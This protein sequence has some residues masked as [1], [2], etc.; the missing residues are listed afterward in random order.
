MRPP[1]HIPK[2]PTATD[3]RP[4][5]KLCSRFWNLLLP[6]LPSGSRRKALN[7]QRARAQLGQ[8]GGGCSGGWE[9]SKHTLYFGCC[10]PIFQFKGKAKSLLLGEAFLPGCGPHTQVVPS[11]W[12]PGLA[13]RSRTRIWGS[14]TSQ[15]QRQAPGNLPGVGSAKPLHWSARSFPQGDRAQA[16]PRSHP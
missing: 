11:A 15:P 5:W 7:L 9:H 6:H 13:H 10:V 3:H 1:V 16:A 8:T 12:G 2:E 4:D 14:H